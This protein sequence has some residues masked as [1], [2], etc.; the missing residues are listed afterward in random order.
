MVKMYN[1]LL[2]FSFLSLLLSNSLWAQQEEDVYTLEQCIDYAI[3]HNESVQNGEIDELISRKKVGE[4]LADGLP[5]V[6]ANLDMNYNPVIPSMV[7]G[8]QEVQMGATYQSTGSISAS[9]LI[10][11]GSYFVGVKAARTYN[12][13]SRKELIRTKTDVLEMVTK[14]Y[15]A[16]LVGMERKELIESNY[17]R[18]DTLFQETSVLFEQ[19][20]AEKIDVSRVKVQ[21][22]NLETDVKNIDLEIAVAYNLL[23]FQMGMPVH[24][25]IEVGESIKDLSF[26]M[27]ED[28]LDK[29]FEASNR[30]EFSILETNLDLVNLDIKNVNAKYF[31]VLDLYGAIGTNGFGVELSDITGFGG[32]YYRNNARVGL[33]L[34][35]PIFDGFRKSKMIQQSKLKVDQIENT[36]RQL[37]NNI[38][39]E[40]KQARV[41]LISARDALIIQDD[42]MELAKEVYDISL[43][44][45]QEGVGS[46]IEVMNAD[47]EYKTAQVNYFVALH[48]A[49][50]AK[51]N[52]QKALGVLDKQ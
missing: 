14:A 32:S 35:L 39:F 37:A 36:K 44:K 7:F 8:G 25:E 13:L 18:L 48:D 17:A 51:V 41:A 22:N 42:N 16:V 49:L 31:P 33:K 20:F 28:D 45:Y 30:I 9:Q 50:N 11:N 43:I 1:K 12:E 34:S 3:E 40:I 26:Q 27:I 38:Q 29:T 10:F 52:L 47:N 4:I 24:N 46:S 5:Q 2:I 23:K 6:N 19:G 15:Y 21:M